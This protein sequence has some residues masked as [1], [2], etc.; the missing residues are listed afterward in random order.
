MFTVMQTGTH[1]PAGLYKNYRGI[2]PFRLATTSYIYP[3]HI[4]PNASWLSSYLD[5]M[6]LILF[7]S[8][9]LPT[10]EE[11]LALSTL[12]N[13][14][15]FSYNVHLPLD[16]SLGHPLHKTRSEGIAAVK[17]V[18]ALTLVLAPTS[19]TLHY[20]YECGYRENL[21]SWQN[22]IARSTETILKTG[23]DPASISVETLDYPL[24]WVEDIIDDF[25]LSICLDLGHIVQNGEEP[26]HYLDKYYEK[27]SV[28]HMHGVHQGRTH[29]G[30]DVVDERVL[31]AWLRRLKGYRGTLSIEVFTFDHLQTSL[32][33]LEKAWARV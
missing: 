32:M 10:R 1:V 15:G 16:I 8:K 26:L 33:A 3:D 4:L 11:I 14:Q 19:Y 9:N 31:A 23:I 17:K 13:K 6:E 21:P 7:E 30:L 12:R 27:T 22:L 2:F 18:V 28:I 25:G 5:E 20:A 24:A 29:L